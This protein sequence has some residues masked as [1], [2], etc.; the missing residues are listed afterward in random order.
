M[1]CGE[2]R[3]NDSCKSQGKIPA[4]LFFSTIRSLP[5]LLMCKILIHL[6]VKGKKENSEGG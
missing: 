6:S 3:K 5:A 4:R 2:L 1:K